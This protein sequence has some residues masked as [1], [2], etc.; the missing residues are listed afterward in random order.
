ME[1]IEH[2]SLSKIQSL[3]DDILFF[4]LDI[5][6]PEVNKEAVVNIEIKIDEA[7]VEKKDESTEGV[8]KEVRIGRF[9]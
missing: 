1:Y 3:K 2:L 6:E 5:T 7:T 4:Y 8:E 9:L